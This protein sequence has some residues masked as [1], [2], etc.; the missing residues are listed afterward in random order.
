MLFIHCLISANWK[1]GWYK[2]V[3]IPRGSFATGRIKLS[4]EVGLTEQQTRTSLNHLKLTNEIT[5]K[6]TNRF[7][8]ITVVNYGVYQDIPDTEQPTKQPTKRQVKKTTPI[9]L[10]I[11]VGLKLVLFSN[12][13]A[14]V[15]K[16][17]RL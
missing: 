13:K 9:P 5:I 8:V 6:S 2:G 11:G 15:R 3:K 1:D 4:E 12:K 17:H 7:S 10:S 16:E 14:E